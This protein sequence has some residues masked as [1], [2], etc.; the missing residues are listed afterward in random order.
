MCDK[1]DIEWLDFDKPKNFE[2]YNPSYNFLAIIK[3]FHTKNK[4]SLMKVKTRMNTRGMFSPTR[5][6]TK[7]A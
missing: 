4:Q 5:K 3:K 7:N 1:K 6:I 2:K